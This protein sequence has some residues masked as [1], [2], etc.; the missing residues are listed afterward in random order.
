MTFA[1]DGNVTARDYAATTGEVSAKN[2][3]KIYSKRLSHIKGNI[4]YGERDYYY[5]VDSNINNKKARTSKYNSIYQSEIK[6][7][8]MDPAANINSKNGYVHGIGAN[9]L[10]KDGHAAFYKSR[11]GL[12][13]Q[14]TIRE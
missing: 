4:I 5:V 2:L 12:T 10:F 9:W 8:G 13:N 11:I 14:F 3:P 1:E 7:W 6:S